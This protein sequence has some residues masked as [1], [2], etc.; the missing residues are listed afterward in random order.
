[1]LLQTAGNVLRPIGFRGMHG[2]KTKRPASRVAEAGRRNRMMVNFGYTA[3]P[4][5]LG[6]TCVNSAW[7][8][9]E[10]IVQADPSHNWQWIDDKVLGLF[11]IT[12][13]V[14]PSIPRRGT[15]HERY[16]AHKGRD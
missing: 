1:M 16:R 4:R 14:T 10:S 5:R 9:A 13:R 7:N 12:G 6:L 8:N 3:A 15:T 11:L 2:L